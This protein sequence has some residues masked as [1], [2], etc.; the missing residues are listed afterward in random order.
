MK[1]WKIVLVFVVLIAN[2]AI[3]QPSFADRP[4]LSKSADYIEV[5]QNLDNLLNAQNS[6]TQPD[7]LTP[8]QLQ[9]QIAQLQFQKYILETGKS[10]GQCR[11]ETGKTL[12]VYGPKPKKSDSPYD[13]ALYLLADGQTTNEKWDCDG[14]YLPSDVQLA[15][16]N[17]ADA[18]QSSGGVAVKI[19]DGTQLVAKTNPQ[20]GA[21]EL[22]IPPAKVFQAGQANWFMPDISQQAISM[23]IPTAPIDD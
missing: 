11:N 17:P 20:T 13:N 7:G 3:A 22:N 12:A 19:V 2:L 15:G 23:Q 21:V 9:Q 10:W 16:L 14:V 4:K 5:T 6:Q 1:L 8:E 18:Q